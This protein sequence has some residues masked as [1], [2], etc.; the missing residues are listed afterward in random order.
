MNTGYNRRDARPYIDFYR[1]EKISPVHQDVSDARHRER[2]ESLYRSLGIL[3]RAVA[4]ANVLE[5]GPG[6]GHNALYTASLRPSTYVLV[7]G[8]PLGLDEC[9]SLLDG[10]F[11]AVRFGFEE[12]FV[13]DLAADRVGDFVF[14][15]GMLSAQHDP[16]A[17]ARLIGKHV[18]PG[19]VFVITCMDDLS[20]VS[21]TTRR[22][23]AHQQVPM[24]QPFAY[25]VEKLVALFGP[26][27]RTLSGMSRSYEDWVIDNIIHP[28]SG[29]LFPI[30]SAVEAL[31]EQFD[32]YGSSPDFVVDWRWYKQLH[33]G[34]RN[35]N[36]RAIKAYRENVLGLLDYRVI[37]GTTD[38]EAGRRARDLAGWIYRAA[39]GADF[40]ESIDYEM[41]IQV[42][43]DLANLVSA[44]VPSAAAALRECRDVLRGRLALANAFAYASFFGR[45]QQYVSLTRRAG[46]PV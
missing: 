35:D 8:N 33:S 10:K 7:D 39:T 26:H 45:G 12:S 5:I 15:E 30:D 23:V 32:F 28:M 46:P 16:A 21:E 18:A 19:G 29:P 4:G 38:P 3:P 11:P 40:G 31:A 2:R 34:A 1:A 6:S 22:L 20:Y 25:R 13:E 36:G 42:I 24:N 17:M 27:L 37:V 44:A 43:E 41:S 14:A 9:R